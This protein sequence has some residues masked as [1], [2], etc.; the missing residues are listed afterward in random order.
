MMFGVSTSSVLDEAES[1][2][3]SAGL[4]FSG[5]ESAMVTGFSLAMSV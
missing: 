4:G 2:R 5:L 1:L 3:P